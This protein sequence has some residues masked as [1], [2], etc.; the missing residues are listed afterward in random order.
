MWQHVVIA[1][2]VRVCAGRCGVLAGALLA[3]RGRPGGRPR[4]AA[5]PPARRPNGQTHQH[6]RGGGWRAD[7]AGGSIPRRQ[8]AA[9]SAGGGYRQLQHPVRRPCVAAAP[10]AALRRWQRQRQ[11]SGTITSRLYW[12][13]GAATSAATATTTASAAAA[14]HRRVWQWRGECRAARHRHGSCRGR[15]RGARSRGNRLRTRVSPWH[16]QRPRPG[17]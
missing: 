12:P 15:N 7:G 14:C 6:G 11:R 5:T 17:A 16:R 8:C 1:A 2:R 3:V 9:P 13:H 4:A 10:R